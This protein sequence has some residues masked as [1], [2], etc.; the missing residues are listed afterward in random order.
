M[1][2]KINRE[3]FLHAL[4]SVQSG[5]SPKDNPEQAN[6]F[7]FLEGKIHTYNDE[8]TCSIASPLGKSFKGA[9][10]AKK[11]L[12]VLRR[13]Q[14][15]EF[16][17]KATSSELIFLGKRKKASFRLEAEVLLPIDDLEKPGK[18]K[19]LPKDFGDAV[20]I[21]H[22]CCGADDS[23][24]NLV[25]VH[26]GS[27]WIESCD[28]FQVCRWPIKL[29]VKESVLIRGASLKHMAAFGMT[30]FSDMTGWVHFRNAQGLVMSFKRYVDDYPDL[31]KHLEGKGEPITLSKGL[32]EAAATCEVFSA[33]DA[34]NNVVV[35]T[36]RDGKMRVR[37]ESTLGSYEEV[38]TVKYEGEEISFGMSP[39]VLADIVKRHTD[40][41]LCPGKLKVDGGNYQYISCLYE[42]K[43]K[44]EQ[45]EETKEDFTKKAK[46]KAAKVFSNGK[47][48]EKQLV[49]SKED[50]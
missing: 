31:A 46:E 36:V 23:Q 45:E 29:D 18:W 25:C 14:D 10:N 40:C 8:I 39:K 44:K 42:M 43:S 38:K 7:V 15:E 34:D 28:Q 11:L 35:I 20:Q 41:L 27:N 47:A 1:T 24:F 50:E 12:D 3:S 6:C 33:D 30:E 49:A 32:A 26:I 13:L 5:L 19:T 16:D 9:T 21:V 22:Q 48:K 4:E 2:I 37:G 17:V